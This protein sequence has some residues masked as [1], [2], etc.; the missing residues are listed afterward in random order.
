M[1]KLVVASAL[2]AVFALMSFEG[3]VGAVVRGVNLGQPAAVPNYTAANPYATNQYTAS[4]STIP[5]ATPTI[6]FAQVN[7]KTINVLAAFNQAKG[8]IQKKKTAGAAI[9]PET[10]G[11]LA[12]LTGAFTLTDKSLIQKGT[13]CQY[14]GVGTLLS[15]KYYKINLSEADLAQLGAQVG[16]SFGAAT[17]A[18]A[19]RTAKTAIAWL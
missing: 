14:I 16:I 12:A 11:C 19:Y 2:S 13:Q 6:T 9:T 18:T 4:L 3:E 17:K 5:T 1:N 15:K 10:F 7:A 8:L